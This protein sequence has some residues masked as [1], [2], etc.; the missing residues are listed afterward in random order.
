VFAAQAAVALGHAQEV[1]NLNQA[2]RS[3]QQIG[4]AVGILIERYDLDEQ[5]AFSFLTR[6]SSHSNVKL[7]DVAA[8]LVEDAVKERREVT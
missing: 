2:L 5:G 3:R 6:L 4:T 1:D 8:R 7:R